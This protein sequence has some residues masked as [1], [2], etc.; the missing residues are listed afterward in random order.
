MGGYLGTL[1][2]AIAGSTLI[3]V[4]VIR[5]SYAILWHPDARGDGL[6]FNFVSDCSW[7]SVHVIVAAAVRQIFR[8]ADLGHQPQSSFLK[9]AAVQT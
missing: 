9:R 3:V 7:I 1:F 8:K 4:M 2:A 5:L 6:L